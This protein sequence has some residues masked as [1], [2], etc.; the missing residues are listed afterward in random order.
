[1]PAFLRSPMVVTIC[2]DLLVMRL[3]M[4]ILRNIFGYGCI[5]MIGGH[6]DGWSVKQESFDQTGETHQLVE[7]YGIDDFSSS[8][9][10]SEDDE[11]G[12]DVR[13]LLL[14]ETD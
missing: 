4:P 12:F 3:Q 13:D 7:E 10:Q 8:G 11:D 9:A 5:G 14:D 6:I 1:M 2:R